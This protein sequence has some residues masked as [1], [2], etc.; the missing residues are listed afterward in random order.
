MNRV[1]SSA[2]RRILARRLA[3][4]SLLRRKGA[5][6]GLVE[7][8]EEC[9]AAVSRPHGVP[10]AGAVVEHRADVSFEPLELVDECGGVNADLLGCGADGRAGYGFPEAVKPLPAVQAALDGEADVGRYVLAEG[11]DHVW[12]A[13]DALGPAGYPVA[14]G[15][16]DD[17]HD[18]DV[19]LGGDVG[20]GAAGV[21]VAEPLR[22]DGGG[23]PR[24]GQGDAMVTGP[25]GQV[26]AGDA[27][28]G[29]DLAEGF[30][31][32]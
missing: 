16:G 3:G 20:V 14:A 2:W 11:G 13:V 10:G 22:V 18:A 26:G 31:R 9:V 28:L 29:L 25:G 17:G 6:G 15:S 24:A 21:L 5:D 4:V 7:G 30:P 32:Y 12:P 23:L 1:A 19:E 8:L 27:R